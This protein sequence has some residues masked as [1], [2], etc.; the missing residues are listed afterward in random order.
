MPLPDMPHATRSAMIRYKPPFRYCL[1]VTLAGILALCLA[2]FLNFPLRGLWAVLTAIVVT[3]VGGGASISAVFEYVVGTVVGAI[4]A[5]VV[6][7]LV[8]HAS[9]GALAWVLTLTVAPLALAAALDPIFKIA[10]F[11]AAIVLLVS[12]GFQESPVES[13]IY[14]VLEVLVGGVSVLAVSFLILPEQAYGRGI[15][16]AMS[17]LERLAQLLP[18]LT[19]GFRQPLDTREAVRLQEGLAGAIAEFESIAAATKM[20]R[21]TYP[22]SAPDLSP[23]SRT[24]LRL[25]HD[26]AMVERAAAEPMPPQILDRLGPLLNE[27]SESISVWLRTCAAALGE[28]REPAPP[29]AIENLL[30]EYKKVFSDLRKQGLVDQLPN[31]ESERL[32]A[33]AFALEQLHRNLCDLQRCVREAGAAPGV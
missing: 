20:E 10:P 15:R 27:I 2:Q 25:R 31:L 12:T 29:G 13:A 30:A 22:H 23:L 18:Q 33:L 26:L 5:G 14:R 21:R 11:T 1:R 8:P 28:R 32:F 7:I 16:S 4:Y 19:S 17:I 9:L 3:Q 24:L 6:S